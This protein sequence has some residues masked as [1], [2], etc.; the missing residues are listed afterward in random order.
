MYVILL[1]SLLILK[2]S[3]SL[4]VICWSRSRESTGRNSTFSKPLDKVWGGISPNT[5]EMVITPWLD[6]QSLVR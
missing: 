4:L 3:F 6:L 1:M 5:D 2:Q